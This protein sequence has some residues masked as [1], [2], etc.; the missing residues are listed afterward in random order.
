M[1][2]VLSFPDLAPCN[3]SESLTK[4]Q[5]AYFKFKISHPCTGTRVLPPSKPRPPAQ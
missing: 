5:N 4:N 2:L 1:G 3:P